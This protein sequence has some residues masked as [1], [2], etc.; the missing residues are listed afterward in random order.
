MCLAVVIENILYL[1]VHLDTILETRLLYHLD[2]AVGLDGTFEK[3]VCLE[4]DDKLILAVDVTGLVRRDCRN[5]NIIKR[6]N[7]VVCSLLFKSLETLVP[8]F[9]CPFGGTRQE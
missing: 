1:F 8:Y 9:F 6:A 2:S 4:T 7:A 5:S 3:L